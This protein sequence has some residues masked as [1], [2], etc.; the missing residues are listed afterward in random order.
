MGSLIFVHKVV[1]PARYFVNRLLE[2]LRVMDE[3]QR[4]SEEV[5]RDVTWFS[6]FL[7]YFNGTSSYIYTPLQCN[8][9]TELDACLTGLG[10]RYNDQVYQYQFADN[11]VNCSFSIVHLEI[12]NVLIGVRWWANRVIVIKCDNEAVVSVVKIGVT[13]YSALAS[14]VRH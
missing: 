10:S 11:E 4:M 2:T 7:K 9:Q 6:N 8:D 14:L 12:C 3:I 13:Q 1:K 5:I